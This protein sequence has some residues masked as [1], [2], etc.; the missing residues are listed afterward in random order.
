MSYSHA[1]SRKTANNLGY[2]C[3]MYMQSE[4][5]RYYKN[6]NLLLGVYHIAEAYE[7]LLIVYAYISIQDGGDPLTILF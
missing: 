2:V 4:T 1:K 6:R 7:L 5:G 3:S